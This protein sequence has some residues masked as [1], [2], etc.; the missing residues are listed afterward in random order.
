MEMIELA[1]R[2]AHGV[3]VALLWSPDS[4]SVMVA[5]SDERTGETFLVEPPRDCALDA[6]YHPFAYAA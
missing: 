2:I 5:V 1:H 3:E 6:F 4:D